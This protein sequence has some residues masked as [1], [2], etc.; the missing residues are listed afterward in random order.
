MAN[1]VLELYDDAALNS[2]KHD[3]NQVEQASYDLPRENLDAI[4][5]APIKPGINKGAQTYTTKIVSKLGMAK[6]VAANAKELP[7]ISLAVTKKTV[8]IQSLGASWDFTQEELDGCAFNNTPLEDT[9]AKAA[10]QTVDEKIDE[11]IYV[12]DKEWGVL[13]LLTN[14]NVTRTIAANNTAGTSKKW[15]DKTLDEITKDVQ[16]MVNAVFEATKGPRGSGTVTPDTI[17]IPRDAF[18][19]LTT[20]YTGSDSKITY[21]EALKSKFAPQG[22]VN[23]ELCNSA[24]GV[25][26]V[27]EEGDADR[28]LLYK[29]AAEN[30]FSIVP[31]SFRVLP[32]QASG[33]CVTFNCYGRCGGAAWRRPTTGCYM[34]GV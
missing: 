8:E 10:R 16:T 2:I 9:E 31:L 23:W 11:M 20:K 28:A 15:K 1:N 7:S 13:G 25:G 30:V 12:G 18:T 4:Q 21:L 29:K 5:S 14:P 24:A 6:I 34:D 17:K 33:L 32:P 22:I 27:S 26:T 19:Y 3:F